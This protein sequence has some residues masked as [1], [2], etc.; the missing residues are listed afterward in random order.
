MS[1][2]REGQA[3]YRK[4][5]SRS[6]DEILGQDHITGLLKKSLEK[7]RISHAYLLTGPRGTG[8]TSIARI[9]AHEI[10]QLPYDEESNHLDIIEIDAASNNGVDDVRALREKAN[11]AP[12]SAKYK[13]YIIDEVHML[14]KPAFN[15]LLKTLEEP[16]QHVVF[17]LA[18]TDADKLPSTILSRTQQYYFHPISNRVIAKQLLNIA[19]SEKFLLDEDAAW[20]I[21]QQS[22]GGFRDSISLLDQLSS[23]AD[24]KKPLTKKHVAQ[25]IGLTDEESI[26]SILKSYD[27]NN[28]PNVLK[29]IE[30]LDEQGVSASIIASQLLTNIRQR[31]DSRPDYI[32]LVGQLIEVS[33]HPHPD[34]RLI[35]ALSQHIA[36]AK[37]SL[38]SPQQPAK[39]SATN[40]PQPI[41]KP[42]LTKPN[43]LTDD[44]DKKPTPLRKDSQVKETVATKVSK[45]TTFD[46]QLFID[47]V[48][49]QSTTLSGLLGNCDFICEGGSLVI[50]AGKPFN[51]KRLETSQNLPL[52]ASALQKVHESDLEIIIK[53]GQKP[54]EDPTLAKVADIMGGGEAV[55]L[56]EMP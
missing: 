14:S 28:L 56:E 5:R 43:T 32:P 54:L 4:Y 19:K 15:A 22:K 44:A 12:V 46:W 37:T 41:Y 7:G 23:L 42:K 9:L 52:L 38:D 47:N 21:A 25:S 33:G 17:I 53:S 36:P 30:Q 35:T 6:L 48:R 24:N 18:T 39:P 11:I 45:S 16:P 55:E 31:L 29:T 8:K 49:R 26:S 2:G 10:N 1:S 34:L 20:L 13:V 27:E 50:F 40:E 51:K 3:L